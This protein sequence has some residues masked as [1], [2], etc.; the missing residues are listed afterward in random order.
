VT[1]IDAHQHYWS[2]QRGD[3]GWLTPRETALYRDFEPQHLSQEL[4]QFSVSAT[5]LV[6]AAPTEAETRFL[7][8]LARQHPSIA[9]VVGWVDFEAFDVAERISNLVRDGRGILKGLRPMVQDIDDSGWLDRP[10]LDAVFE[11]MIA[12]DLA[13]DA[14]VMPRHLG[15]TARRLRRHPQLRAIVDHAGKPD[16]SSAN[17]EP[18]AAQIEQLARDTKAYCKLSGL[19]TQA[20]QGVGIDGLDAVVAHVFDCFGAERVMWGSDWP[21][22]T[23]RAPYREWLEMSLELVRRHA[24]GREDAVFGANAVA[25]YHL[26]VAPIKPSDGY[27]RS[28]AESA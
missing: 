2:V 15:A 27:G 20:D 16:I 23:L 13:F 8:D 9:G 22:V 25:F 3:Y 28:G 21:V 1:R 4:A 24:P 26:E 6:Q 17:L 14:L 10:S 11:V 12:H 18:W 5:V 7:F 19:L